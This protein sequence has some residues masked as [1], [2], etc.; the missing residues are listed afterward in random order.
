MEPEGNVDRRS[1]TADWRAI[2]I[3]N[4]AGAGSRQGNRVT[5]LRYARIFRGLG[6]SVC[7]SPR[8]ERPSRSGHSSVR[9][10]AR[11][12]AAGWRG[13]AVL[14]ALHARKSASI[15]ADWST[16]YP[17]CPIVL[18]L[19]GTDLYEEFGRDRR[20]EQSLDLA[21]RIVVLQ[22]DALRYLPDRY[23]AKSRVI[24]QSAVAPRRRL[25]PLKSVFEICV[26]GHLREVKDPLRAAI[27]AR[28]LPAD[29]RIR[30]HQLGACLEPKWQ[31]RIAREQA[32]N[33]R[34]KYAGSLP[35]H[36]ARRLMARSRLLVV[37]SR[38]EGAPNVASEAIAAGVPIV[39]SRISGMVGILGEDYPGYFKVGD[40]LGL[41]DAMLRAEQDRSWYA[42]L[43]R[44]IRAL[45]P[46]VAPGRES[47]EWD[48]LLRELAAD[49]RRPGC[50]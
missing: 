41:R 34:L 8:Y 3:A 26:S 25:S 15:I 24:V 18:V 10:S 19:T 40:T 47:A 27:A 5:A 48:R 33:G 7:G 1:L 45:R 38:S 46:L 37:S 4:P 9:R 28:S 12:D 14:V 31:R 23:L 16:D 49:L 42:E 6:I 22:R 50:T 43:R 39:S 29:S 35:P 20:I 21:H 44:R 2:V 36:R 17:Q 11:A 32:M 13:R 30:I